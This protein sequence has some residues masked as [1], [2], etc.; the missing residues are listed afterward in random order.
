MNEQRH[1]F[2]HGSESFGTDWWDQ[3]GLKTTT[4]PKT[5]CSE[6]SRRDAALSVLRA[7]PPVAFA[8]SEAQLTLEQVID[9]IR[10]T[11]QDVDEARAAEA[12]R[13]RQLGWE[14]LEALYA[15]ADAEEVIAGG[16][17]AG[18][19]R[20]RAGAWCWN[21][22]D[23]EPVG[24]ISPGSMLREH[25]LRELCEGRIPTVFGYPDR[26]RALEANG[27]SPRDYRRAKEALGATPFNRAD[28]S[29]G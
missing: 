17:W 24:L 29:F 8:G 25:S 20:A 12:E 23:Y 4:G 26:A 15:A 22:F 13:R 18:F 11:E 21:L 2:S 7:H 28:V 10:Q 9:L 6:R 5:T 14:R 3:L 1:C 16:D 19:T 27:L